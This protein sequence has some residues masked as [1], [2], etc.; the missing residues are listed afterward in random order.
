MKKAEYIKQYINKKIQVV[1]K[2]KSY[3]KILVVLSILILLLGANCVS[4]YKNMSVP[5]EK[6]SFIKNEIENGIHELTTYSVTYKDS[7]SKIATK[8]RRTI[9]YINENI[10]EDEK[11]ALP[12]LKENMLKKYNKKGNTIDFKIYEKGFCFILE[13][14][15]SQT[16]KA[17]F[18]TDIFNIPYHKETTLMEIESMLTKTDF[19]EW[20]DIKI[21][22]LDILL[23]IEMSKQV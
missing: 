5:E 18:A 2:Y 8:L 12:E 10:E 21:S 16:T 22:Q 17:T 15:L 11:L 20:K 14:N 4:F 6:R 19:N 9:I 3:H 7:K 1:K 23:L 13:T